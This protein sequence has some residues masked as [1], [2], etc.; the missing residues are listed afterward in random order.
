LDTSFA[1]EVLARVGRFEFVF[2]TVVGWGDRTS[3][4]DGSGKVTTPEKLSL[5]YP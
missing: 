3:F 1:R 4:E 2:S 5:I